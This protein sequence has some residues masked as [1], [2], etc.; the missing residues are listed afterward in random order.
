MTTEEIRTLTF[1]CALTIFI[2]GIFLVVTL[3]FLHRKK[4]KFIDMESKLK[5]FP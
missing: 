3:V 5:T 2:V 1:I 4:R